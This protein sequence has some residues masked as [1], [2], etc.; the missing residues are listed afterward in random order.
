MKNY[1]TL[2]M[3]GW[4]M[5]S[6][7]QAAQEQPN[8]ACDTTIIVLKFPYGELNQIEKDHIL[9]MV[10][11]EKLFEQV[12]LKLNEKWQHEVFQTIP[13][14]EERHSKAVE[15]LLTKYQIVS[16]QTD[17]VEGTIFNA[18]LTKLHDDWITQGSISLAEAL[19]VSAIMKEKYLVELQN[20]L[21]NTAVD[22][23]DIQFVY[24]NLAKGSRNHLRTLVS[25]L[26]ERDL[27]Y[28]PHHLQQPNFQEIIQSPPERSAYEDSD[29]LACNRNQNQQNQEAIQAK[30]SEQ[31]VRQMQQKQQAQQFQP[32]YEEKNVQYSE[33][34]IHE[35]DE[36]DD[37]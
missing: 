16:P 26:K 34:E 6:F 30:S 31:W 13:Q 27:E 1:A 9:Q 20:T 8:L 36:D 28:Q 35:E 33:Y 32:Q 14:S 4:V 29:Q 11:L 7:A 19:T 17:Q 23:F 5:V 37:D 25:L 15:A 18:S 22:N 3:L 12:Y 24:K 10:Q 2:I 21:S